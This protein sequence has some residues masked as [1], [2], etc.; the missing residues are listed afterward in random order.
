MSKTNYTFRNKVINALTLLSLMIAG[1]TNAQTL[2]SPYGVVGFTG[3]T[4]SESSVTEPSEI[5]WQLDG[6]GVS[7]ITPTISAS[8][9]T[10]AGSSSGVYGQGASQLFYPGWATFDATG[11][12]YIADASNSRVQK[13]SPGATSGVTVAG[14]SSGVS[15]SDASHLNTPYS[16]YVDGS[17]NVYV[18]DYNNNRIQKWAPG[19]SSGTTVAGGAYGT[20]ASQF[21]FPA[22]VY[23]DMDGNI[24]VADAGNNR[25]QKWAPGASSGVTVAGTGSAGSGAN[26][27]SNPYGI[28]LDASGNLYIADQGNH[29]IQKWAAGASTGTTVAGISGISGSDAAHLNSPT[30]VYVDGSGNVFVADRQ[31]HRIQMWFAGAT[32]GTTVAGT[33]SSG[34]GANQLSYPTSVYVDA[35][36]TIITADQFNHRIQQFAATISHTITATAP[37]SY[38]SLVT[39]GSETTTTNVVTVNGLP[40]VGFTGSTVTCAGDPAM[41]IGTGATSYSWT[42]GV[43]NGVSF[44]PATGI[45][46]YTVTGSNS[47]GSN[48][49]IATVTSN[50]LPTVGITGGGSEICAGTSATLS[51]TGAT[52][53]SWTGGIT[54]GSAFTPSAG[55]H[56]Y[57][58]TGT[59]SDCSNTATTT[60]TVDAL[61]IVGIA[62][63]DI[64]ICSGA[65]AT[66]GGTGASSYSWTG[67]VTNGIPFTPVVG[68][69][70]YTV[71]GTTNGCS[72]NATTTITVNALPTVGATGGG[73]A[74]CSGTM[75][76]LSG[77]G[78]TSYSWTGGITN[79]VAFT[80]SVGINTY[81]VTGTDANGCSNTGIAAVTVNALPT[82]GSTGGGI[83]ICSG[84]MATLNGTGATSYSWT[85]G[86]SNGVP[87]TP[88]AGVNSYTVTGTTS[89]C[90]NTATTTITVN[91]ANPGIISG[92]SSV[93]AGANITLTDATGSGAWSASNG[94]ATVTGGVV[95]G[96]TAGTVTISYTVTSGSCTASAT[97]LIT[98][99]PSGVGGITGTLSLCQGSTTALTDATPGGTWHSSN[100]LVATV[101]TSGI[102]SATATGSVSATATISYTVGGIPTT[103]IVTVNPN[104]SGIGGASSVCSGSSITLS[105]F[106]AGGLWSATSSNVTVGSSG[107]VTGTTAGTA[108][109]TYALTTGCYRTYNIMVNNSPT[110][111]LGNTTV[112]QGSTTFLSDAIGPTVSW[113]SGNTTVA[114]ISASGACLGV[115]PGTSSITYTI[116]AGCKTTAT[117]TVTAHPAAITN[118]ALI[119][120]PGSIVLSDATVS[121]TWSSSNSAIGSVNSSSGTVT[122]VAT[123]TATITYATGGTGCYAVATVTVNASAGAGSLS[124]A[125]TVCAGSTTALSDAAP[126]GVWSSTNPVVGTVST[127][128]VVRGLSAG[129]TTISYTV[130]NSCGTTVATAVLTVNPLPVAGT[131]SG[132]TGAICAG[133]VLALT[134]AA[135]GGVWTSSNTA[136]GS[137]DA[138]GNVT[139]V[140][141]GVSFITYTVTNGCG[142]AISSTAVTVNAFSA[143]MVTGPTFLTVGLTDHLSETVTGGLWSASNSNATVSGTGLITGVAAGTVIF[144]YTVSNGCGTLTAT[145]NVTVVGSGLP[146][147]TGTLNICQG[148]TS[149]LTDADP[150]GTWHSSNTL[151][152]TVGTSG[153]VTATATGA[154][155]AT[156]TISYTI[157]GVPV[158]V[159]VT[160]NPNPSGIGGSSSVCYGASI[161]L[162]DFTAGGT[163]TTTAGVT[164]TP[165]SSATVTGVTGAALGTSTVTYALATGCARTWPVTVKAL[166][167]SILGTTTVCGVTGVTFL[168]DPTSGG[169]WAVTPVGTATITASGRVYGVSVGTA[170]VTYTG[171]N[172]CYTTT[173]VT[174]IAAVTVPTISG[175]SSVGHG[176]TITLSDATTGGTWTSNNPLLGSVDASGDVTGVGTS[177][178]VT[179]TYTVPYGAG[180]TAFATKPI[181]VHTPAPPAHGTTVGGTITMAAGTVVSLDDDITSGIWSSSNTSVV[182]VD[183]GLL[184]AVAPGA[185]NITHIVTNSDGSSS[186]SVTPVVVSSVPMDVSVVPNPNNGTFNVKGIMSTT[187]DVEVTLEVTDVLGQVIYNNTVTAEGGRVNET[188]SLS[189]TLANGMYMVNVHTATE[190]KVCHFVVGR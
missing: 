61:P 99:N 161:T 165:G 20:G 147:I 35:S 64:G 186:T 151:V 72:N 10:I 182:T 163:W 79:G 170:T 114:T 125:G 153:I 87:F 89:G 155:A 21:K 185:A 128:G 152:A 158:S 58:V 47:C 74:I 174:V 123:G 12:L 116:A 139:G 149:A 70:V 29:R 124:G 93:T 188:I 134:D 45:T 173:V 154:V 90:S 138:S 54:D 2:S 92:P 183:G 131:I 91:V 111:I 57:T 53:Y 34:L 7:T 51:G 80:P 17:N 129:T 156:A 86:I 132:N 142:I 110:A 44:I 50:A 141:G 127:A 41:L 84:A 164:L 26:Q 169:T 121:G 68:V 33:G 82:V 83:S 166:P 16:V 187:Q 1:T 179:I 190:Q 48:T 150:G 135:A 96:V 22:G 133:S 126:G 181:T 162:S 101:G 175:S 81:T 88:S 59:T 112:C 76:T 115:N 100:T 42:G 178:T 106:T 130:T 69:N 14:A 148:Q 94:N 176:L 103:V 28:Y 146:G 85:G 36:S 160:V 136:I 159:V 52:S 180:C 105:D 145:L 19:A 122:G 18:A 55:V 97:L 107:T 13:W 66:L 102:V 168:S 27:L 189:G 98:V 65:T 62:G 49:A 43:I 23:V 144:S 113:A 60:V 172:T 63:G 6:V 38:T 11:N 137:V 37:G 73:A 104:P 119:C 31:N 117:V 143:G 56:S 171:T 30:G 40:S 95:H 46:T 39:I 9:T 157:G 32:S 77:T 177:G 167:S 184:T 4:L 120:L 3:N 75:A 71:I 8:A 108:A 140:G 109:I 15:G 5:V 118:N 25:I 67:G 24:Y 78:A